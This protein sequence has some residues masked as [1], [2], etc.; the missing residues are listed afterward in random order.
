MFEELDPERVGVINR[1]RFVTLTRR[2]APTKSESTVTT[3]LEALDP[4]N[5][6]MIT[7]SDAANALLPDIRRACVKA[8]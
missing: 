5:H 1:P 6:D 8:N 4:F 2:L 7:F 3:L